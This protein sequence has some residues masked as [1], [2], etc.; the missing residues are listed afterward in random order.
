ME[1]LTELIICVYKWLYESLV[2]GISYDVC[3]WFMIMNGG[4]SQWTGKSYL[5]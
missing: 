5:C 1:W 4:I 2:Y 3:E